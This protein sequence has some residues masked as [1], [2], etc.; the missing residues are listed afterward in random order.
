MQCR[1]GSQPKVPCKY[2]RVLTDVNDWTGEFQGV[3]VDAP[4]QGSEASPT[5][6]GV[7]HMVTSSEEQSVG[8]GEGRVTRQTPPQLGDVVNVISDESW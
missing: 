6:E 1:I 5:P 3:Y 7:M 8:S 2:P 4:P